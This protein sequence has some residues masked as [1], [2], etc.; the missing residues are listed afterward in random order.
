[1]S[2]GE[3][4]RAS[5]PELA[6]KQ[7]DQPDDSLV[8]D[9]GLERPLRLDSGVDFAPLRIAYTTAGKLNAA[10]SNAVLVCHALTGDQ[11]VASVH[12]VTGRAGWWD[13]LVG[14]GKPIDTERFFVI[15]P[16]VIGSCMGSSGPASTN[17]A[18]GRPYGL[19][20]P[21]VTIA[22]MVRAQAML[23]DHLGIESLFAVL[24][25]SMGGMLVLQWAA[26]YPERVFS[27]LCIASAARHTAQNIAFNEVGRQAIMAD[28]D[29]RGGHY[30]EAGIRPAKGLGVARMAAHITYLSEDALQRK[31]GRNLQDRAAR[32][33]T[34]DADFQIE[35][36]LRYQGLSFVE[37]FDANS[38]LYV[39]RAM[40]Y[41][42]LAAEYGGSLAAAFRG[43]HTRFCVASFTSDWLF[44]TSASRQ[45]MHA[46]NAAG[47][48]VSF[49]EIETDKG[50][51][52][53]LLDIPELFDM[54]RG[55]V[56]AAARERGVA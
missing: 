55:F 26:S 43:T 16:N 46:L 35:S 6:R 53:F 19:D 33:F 11:H 36:Y 20:F 9:F 10:K 2:E 22:D 37:R 44:P 3:Q 5:F 7:A 1:M 39:T 21:V 25:G 54:V 41:F 15:C 50:H 32:T 29:W 38:Y 4:L 34:F 52:A 45:I 13:T 23:L 48:R 56:G 42:D 51:D 49:V 8:V 28:P 18:T 27:A 17:P 47:A 30:I 40:D 14:P 31:F 24:G 12:P